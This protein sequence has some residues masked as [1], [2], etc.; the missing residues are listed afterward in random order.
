MTGLTDQEFHTLGV[1]LVEPP[2]QR[3]ERVY[4][5]YRIVTVTTSDPS[6]QLLPASEDRVCAY[7][8]ALDDDVVLSN[9]ESDANAG[10][11]TRVPKT[12]TAPWPIYDQGVLYAAVPVLAGATSRISVSAYYRVGE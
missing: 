8:Q 10:A 5:T 3:R 1:R 2:P 4:G 6:S 12:N 7:V 11:G 9:R